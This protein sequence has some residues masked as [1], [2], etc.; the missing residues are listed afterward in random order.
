[1]FHECE[2]SEK[3]INLKKNWKWRP[4]ER[5]GHKSEDNTK[6]DINYEYVEL[7]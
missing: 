7:S 4:F 5:P 1:M 3:H 6:T 2:K